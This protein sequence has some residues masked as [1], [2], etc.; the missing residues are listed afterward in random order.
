M[1][2]R[3]VNQQTYHIDLEPDPSGGFTAT[4]REFPGCIAEGDSRETALL[5]ILSVAQEWLEISTRR[6]WVVPVFTESDNGGQASPDITH[7]FDAHA[8]WA[9]TEE[10][11]RQQGDDV[12][13][14]TREAAKRIAAWEAVAV[15]PRDVT[16]DDDEVSA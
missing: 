13:Q 14:M 8:L 12:D 11:M 1:G 3:T 16:R 10:Y 6:G 5:S 15:D 4:I 9:S 7:A 2:R